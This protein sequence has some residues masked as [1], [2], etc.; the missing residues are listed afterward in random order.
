MSLLPL[1]RAADTSYLMPG[2]V[3][4]NLTALLVG[5]LL[6]GLLASILAVLHHAL[7]A[8][9]FGRLIDAGA[10]SP[11]TAKTLAELGLSRDFWLRR[12]LAAPHS[13][14]RK[15]V[16]AVLPDG[17]VLAPLPSLDDG[18]GADRTATT[19]TSAK[20]RPEVARAAFF[21]TDM[22]RR[23]AEVRFPRRGNELVLLIPAILAF[24]ALA[25][26]LPLYLPYFAELLDALIGRVLGG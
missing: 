8:R 19:A 21:L 14:V 5:A 15:L 9:F 26:T 24:V 22:H 4:F 7:G 12:A 11:E 6:G 1:L 20:R 17:T 25:V 18:E 3:A 10:T 2:G 13:L 23:R 16:S